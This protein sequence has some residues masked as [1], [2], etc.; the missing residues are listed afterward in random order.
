MTT[1]TRTIPTVELGTTGTQVSAIALGA[2]PMGTLADE[3]TSV[4]LLDRYAEDGG[5]FLDTAD[6]YAWWWAQ[7][8]EGGQS[9]ELL[10]RWFAARGNRDDIFLATKGSA[11]LRDP[12]A[13]WPS[14]DTEPDWEVARRQFVGA[15]APVLRRSLEAS[16]RR[17]RTDHVDLYLVH[18]D[19][20]ATD[21][22]ETLE[23]LASFVTEGK[24]R[25][26]GWS[27]V[28]TWRLERIR[29]LCERHGWP[30]PV[31]LQQQHSYLQ[32]RPGLDHAS[33]VDEEQLHYL[34]THPDLGLVAY[35]PV[36]KG[37]YDLPADERRAH[38]VNEPYAGEHSERRVAAVQAV[39]RD[40]GVPATRVVLAW[41]LAQREPRVIPLLGTSRVD[42]YTDQVAALDLELSAEELATLD[43]AGPA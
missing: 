38:W 21:L 33:I 27:N 7:G 12:L 11:T 43:G 23:A 16:L 39:A 19:D 41:L 25:Y 6:C 36:L 10:G 5:A 29:G 30:T 40:R 42:R 22:E 13:A 2:M 34:R 24:I 18:V 31:A 35:S 26:Y 8:T 9:E 4:A 14:P 3:E 32:R 1:T 17:L 37:L 20:L 15:S 28:H